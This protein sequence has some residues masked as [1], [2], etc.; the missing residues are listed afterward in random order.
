MLKG[1]TTDCHPDHTECANLILPL[2]D[3]LEIL[4]GK[5]KLPIIM[6]LSFGNKRFKEI[7]EEIPGITDKMLSKELKELEKI[8]LIDRK[9][10]DSFPPGVE[11]SITA[12]G[13][14]L[15]KV[16]L[17]LT[18]WAVTHQQKNQPSKKSKK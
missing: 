9:V 11:Y 7:G 6:S 12:H 17:E 18:Q 8:Q 2:R 13:K 3:A 15:E 16:I 1:K 14:S 5:W 4:S 10:I